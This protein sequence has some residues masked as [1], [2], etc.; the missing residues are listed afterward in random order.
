[1]VDQTSTVILAG[2]EDLVSP[3]LSRTPGRTLLAQNYEPDQEGGYKRIDGYERFD[4]RTAPSSLPSDTT[5]EQAAVEAQRALI[6]AVPGSGPVR[7]VWVYGNKVYAFRNNAGGTE[8]RMYESSG[9]GWAE[10]AAF[11]ALAY[12]PGGKYEFRN[13]NFGGHAGTEKMYGV[14]GVD[15]AFEFDG[16]TITEITTGMTTDTPSHLETHQNYLWLSFAGGSLQ[17]SPLGDPTGTWTP[18]TGANEFGVGSEIT[19]MLAL[20]GGTMAIFCEKR[21]YILQG[22]SSSDWLLAMLTD[23]AGAKEWSIQYLAGGKAVNDIGYFDL[24][25]TDRFGDFAQATFSKDIEPFIRAYVN[26]I[27]CS[28]T[29]KRKNQ[30][31]VMFDDGTVSIAGFSDQ[32]FLGFTRAKYSMVPNVCVSGQINEEERLFVGA[33]DGFVYEVDSGT[34]FDGGVVQAFFRTVYNPLGSPRVRKRFKELTVH[35]DAVQ[36][37]A[38]QFSVDFATTEAKAE[39]VVT[40]DAQG[41]GGFWNISEWDSFLWSL[42]EVSEA[43]TYI[44]GTARS[45]SLLVYSNLTY[46][47]PYT[48]QALIWRYEPR[49]LQR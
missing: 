16:T 37:V 4:G 25:T 11:T 13:F 15:K 12:A 49:R 48:L 23:D 34:N 33:N 43:N 29:I 45:V 41:G 9:S 3:F 27:N 40:L 18:L 26:R 36:E 1:M 35:V 5:S 17:N 19:G 10:V 31:R 20:P 32:G 30:M 47:S 6:T 38:L 8:A 21:I 42:P 39:P 22:S 28:L 7:G 46:E 2:G 44:S 24:S 14:S